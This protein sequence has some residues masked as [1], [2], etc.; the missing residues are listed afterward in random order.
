MIIIKKNSK[1]PTYIYLLLLKKKTEQN[2]KRYNFL[3]LLNERPVII[4]ITEKVVR[5]IDMEP[6][7]VKENNHCK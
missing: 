5:M 1:E 2:V 3:T 4:I 7:N 6:H